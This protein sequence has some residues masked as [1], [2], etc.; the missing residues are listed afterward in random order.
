MHLCWLKMIL[1]NYAL[2]GRFQIF[3]AQNVNW[4]VTEGF[5][6]LDQENP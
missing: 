2:H 4:C 5:R 6:R 1:L 3:L